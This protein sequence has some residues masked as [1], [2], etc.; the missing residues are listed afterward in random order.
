MTAVFNILKGNWTTDNR[1]L[2]ESPADW[3]SPGLDSYKDNPPA[4]D[5]GKVIIADVDHI[6]PNSPPQAWIWKCFLRG[7][8]PI[9]MD[10]YTYSVSLH[11]ISKDQQE[12]MW[13]ALTDKTAL[14]ENVMVTADGTIDFLDERVPRG[15][16]NDAGVLDFEIDE[17]RGGLIGGW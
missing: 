6:W 11:G 5:G 15:I 1:A 8:H 12:A 16:E 14:L 3:I 13:H 2:F 17:L 7:L 4:A 9:H 10:S